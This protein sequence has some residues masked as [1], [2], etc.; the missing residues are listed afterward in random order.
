[1]PFMPFAILG[2]W[3]RGLLALGLL[4]GGIWLLA[5]WYDA[6][7]RVTPVVQT[8]P[9][10]TRPP[11][12][13]LSFGERVTHWHPDLSGET[14]AL[15]GGLLL[16]LVASGGGLL[17]Y[18]FR[19]RSG[20]PVPLPARARSVEHL[21]GPDGTTLHLE[22]YG[23]PDAPPLL[24]THGWG[25]TSAQWYYLLQEMGERYRLV[26]WD[27]PGL[28]HSTRPTPPDYS[29][30]LMARALDV[31]LTFLGPRPVVLVGH[32]IGG[33]VL[34]TLCRLFPAT[35]GRV[36]GMVLAHTTYTNPV[37]TTAKHRLYTALQKPVLEPLLHL[38]IWLSPVLWLLNVLSYLNGSAHASTARQ[39]FAGTQTRQ[40]VQFV[41]R[42]LLHTSPAVLARGMLGM[43]RYDA[44]TT[45][46][47]LEV[48]VLLVA[49]DQDTTTIP[50]ASTFMRAAI[51][52]AQLTT[53]TPAKHQGLL[54]HHAPFA[55]AVA[56][57][58]DVCRRPDAPTRRREG[59][60][61]SS[62]DPR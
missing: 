31:I 18:P 32:S 29:L 46:A 58:A 12:R 15:G 5:T 8:D 36:G 53:L 3:F 43:L 51:P 52:G 11:A 56:A 28:G 9:A 21:P 25:V 47:T 26:L 30:D 20:P 57:F 45:L 10:G 61:R 50:E 34:L 44:T 2:I 16:V 24:V 59:D 35:L 48:P 19:W 62:L 13:P 42:C 7:P 27:L 37:R 49:G 4:G 41:T 17:V 60:T 22:L 6:L 40:Q 23:P 33:M 1:M 39:S 14:A 55:Q 54:E 38:A